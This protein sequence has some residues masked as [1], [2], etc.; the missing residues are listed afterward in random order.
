MTR[1]L[2]ENNDCY[3]NGMAGIGTEEKA[4]PIIIKNRCYENKLAGIG[5][6]KFAR[7]KI[8]GNRC[9]WNQNAGIGSAGGAEP[10]IKGNECFKNKLS[11]IS[12]RGNAL[13]LIVDNYCHHN[14]AG[15]IGF[16]A[17]KV[18]RA[19][20]RNNRVI[21][22][23]LVAVGIHSGWIVQLSGNEFSRRGGLPPIVAVLEG[24]T[25][26]FTDNII[27][28]EGI[29]GILV[30]GT[31]IANNNRLEGFTLRKFGPPNLGVW[32]LKGATVSLSQNRIISWQHALYAL[33]ATVNADHNMVQDFHRTAFVINNSSLPANVFDN[34]VISA[35]Q[36]DKI[37]EIQ[38]AS[39]KIM[40]NEL[41]ET[42]L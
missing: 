29:A 42:S 14:F 10:L 15:G 13:S 22:N 12:H 19:T 16:Y 40:N 39:G 9:Y 3:Q 7:P 23:R 33:S 4:E 27:R 24:A 1:P 28:G 11:G 21:D 6:N 36:H 20:V 31:M 41:R 25:A 18:G 38:G 8:I 30:A 37:L 17:C 26:T 34:I 35:S 32:A 2:I 5:S